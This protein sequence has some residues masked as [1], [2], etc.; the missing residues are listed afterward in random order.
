MQGRFTFRVE[1]GETNE[2]E[3]PNM[4]RSVEGEHV[5]TGMSQ[6]TG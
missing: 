4:A 1:K 2:S 5:F 6:V 3:G